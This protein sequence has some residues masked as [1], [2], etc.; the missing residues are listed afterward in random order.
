VQ[1]PPSACPVLL[2]LLRSATGR[3]RFSFPGRSGVR[4]SRLVQSGRRRDRCFSAASLEAW[5]V[6]AF[7]ER[8]GNDVSRIAGGAAW[9]PVRNPRPGAGG[10]ALRASLGRRGAL[11]AVH[12]LWLAR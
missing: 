6:R 2:K 1:E 5:L 12:A 4:L 8:H 7:A 11:A 3:V 9:G 10:L